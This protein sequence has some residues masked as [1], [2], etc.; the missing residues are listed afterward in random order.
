ML[1]MRARCRSYGGVDYGM[2]PVAPRTAAQSPP[3]SELDCGLSPS[4]SPTSPTTSL[5]RIQ[6]LLAVAIPETNTERY[7]T[8]THVPPHFRP[9]H[10]PPSD[11]APLDSTSRH[12]FRT[13][14]ANSASSA[15]TR[16]R[17]SPGLPHFSLQTPELA[18][19]KPVK[20]PRAEI[21]PAACLSLNAQ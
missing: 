11:A 4:A 16:L 15:P 17:S 6:S 21:V 3:H 7:S 20:P 5:N 18:L 12:A 2:V 19:Y 8:S 13:P 1:A 10:L 14:A 9:R